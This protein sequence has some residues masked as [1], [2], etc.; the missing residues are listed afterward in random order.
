MLKVAG[1]GGGATGAVNYKGTWNANSNSPMLTSSVGNQGDYYVVNIAGTTNLNGITD[2]QVGDW[3]IFNGSVWQ[4]VDN[5]D[6]VTSVNGQTGVVVLGVANIAGAVPNTVNVIAGTGMS[7][8]G[9]L[10]G[11]VTLDLANT[12]VTAATYGNATSVAQVTIDAQGRITN[13]A[14][15]TIA[16]STANVSGLGT[17]A[18]QNA[19]A[20]TITGGDVTANLTSNNVNLTGTTAANATFVTSELPLVPEGYLTVQIGGVNKKIPYYGV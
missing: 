10:T 2:W 7:G 17:M 16:I 12:A 18:T 8:G 13:A 9:A 15:V 4:K 5:T 20:V 11:N 6:G 3:A 19:N 14:N 1:G